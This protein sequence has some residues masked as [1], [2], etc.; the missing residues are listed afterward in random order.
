MLMNIIDIRRYMMKKTRR[1]ALVSLLLALALGISVAA[2]GVLQGDV[3]GDG[4]LNSADAI[5]LLRHT[6]MPTVYPANQAIDMNGDGIQNSAD[7]IYL[8]RHTIMPSVYPLKND[9]VN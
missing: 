9:D 8:L 1:I 4:I 2:D 7:A 5:Y 6:I 3:N